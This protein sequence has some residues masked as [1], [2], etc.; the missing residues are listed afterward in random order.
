MS[1]ANK[2]SFIYSFPIY[3]PFLLF[4][5]LIVLAKASSTMLKSSGERR[6]LDLVPDLSVKA[7]SF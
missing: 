4:S 3:M 7:S 1:S 5:C 6:H 2:G